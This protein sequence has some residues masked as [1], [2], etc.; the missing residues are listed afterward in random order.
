MKVDFTLLTVDHWCVCVDV[1]DWRGVSI[2]EKV[3][4]E[5]QLYIQHGTRLTDCKEINEFHAEIKGFLM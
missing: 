3:A 1:L 5:L 2:D 4:N